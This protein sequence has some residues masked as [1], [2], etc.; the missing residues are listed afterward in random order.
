MSKAP[1]WFVA[2]AI[3]ALLWNLLGCVAFFEDLQL[4]HQDV[5]KLGAAQQALY[6]ARP[7]WALMATAFA[8][9]GGA[10]GCIGLLLRR[11]W[12]VVLLWLS[13][14]GILAQDFGLFVLAHGASFVG[15]VVIVLQLLVLAIAIGLVFLGRKA[16]ARGWLA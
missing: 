16:T 2:V 14:L 10:L 1:K 12:A 5:A 4:S 7:W 13:L 6:D 8:V 3:V 9:F 11:K 15:P